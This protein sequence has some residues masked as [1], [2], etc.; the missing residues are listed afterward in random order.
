[1]LKKLS[2]QFSINPDTRKAAAWR[3]LKEKSQ[4]HNFLLYS[5]RLIWMDDEKLA[6]AIKEWGD[7]PGMP[8]DRRFFLYDTARTIAGKV[9][10]DT[11]DVGVRYGSSSFFMLK[12]MNDP[13]RK[14][15]IFDSFEGLSEPSSEDKA[16]KTRLKWKKG[17]LAVD[18]TV[19]R[20]NL[21]MFANCEFYKGWVPDRFPEVAD[22]KFALVHLDLDLYQ[23]TLDSLK[24]FYER[25]NPGG[26]II[27]DDYGLGSCPGSKQ[28]MDEFFQGKEP[29][30]HIPTGQGM[31]IKQ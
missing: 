19:T 22:K 5:S 30:F 10:G 31:V 9:Q 7:I 16:A 17:D 3:S 8:A 25:V 14:H 4:K 1:M 12:A 23:P 6:Q 11:A 13:S 27:C 20:K 15:H 2:K 18:E 21:F 29:V 24:F 26:V 28:A